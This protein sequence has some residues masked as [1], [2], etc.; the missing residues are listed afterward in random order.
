[1]KRE[2]GAPHELEQRVDPGVMARGSRERLVRHAP[3]VKDD[4]ARKRGVG[5]RN[6]SRGRDRVQGQGREG[7]ARVARMSGLAMGLAA[8]A[9]ALIATGA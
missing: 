8:S 1:M 3:A 2:A 5:S 9:V 7:N 6:R 4:P